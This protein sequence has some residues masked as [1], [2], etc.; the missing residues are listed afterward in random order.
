MLFTFVRASFGQDPLTVREF[1]IEI[2]NISTDFTNTKEQFQG[3]KNAFDKIEFPTWDSS[4]ST[5][6]DQYLL[7]KEYPYMHV[8]WKGEYKIDESGNLI[9]PNGAKYE[10]Y[11]YRLDDYSETVFLTCRGPS[12]FDELLYQLK[13]L[14]LSDEDSFLNGIIKA[15]LYLNSFIDYIAS[16]LDMFLQLFMVLFAMAKDT[17]FFFVDVVL[18]LL[19]MVGIDTVG[20]VPAV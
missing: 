10:K 20:K 6:E 19:K 5:E 2:S 11:E 1:V 17:V 7:K 4:L 8:F 13:D 18:F 15:F 16:V 12:L 3:L 14:L 9:A